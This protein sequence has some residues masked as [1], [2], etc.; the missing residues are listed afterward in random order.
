MT[1]LDPVWTRPRK[2]VPKHAA[3]LL[4]HRELP[5]CLAAATVRSVVSPFA[6]I[7]AVAWRLSSMT[8]AADAVRVA[9]DSGACARACMPTSLRATSAGRA[10]GLLE[11]EDDRQQHRLRVRISSPGLQ[12]DAHPHKVSYGLFPSRTISRAPTSL[13]WHRSSEAERGIMLRASRR[14]I[15]AAFKTLS[16]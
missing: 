7:T 5:I 1:R 15:N 14:P 9:S 2:T 16:A 8:S 3:E 12:D 13:P 4:D 10:R 11:L 6:K